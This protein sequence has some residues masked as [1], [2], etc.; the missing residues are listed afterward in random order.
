M[1]RG[2]S[3]L[4]RLIASTCPGTVDSRVQVGDLVAVANPN[5]PWSAG[6]DQP[7]GEGAEVHSVPLGTRLAAIGSLPLRPL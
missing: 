4:M 5:T 3:L 1:L 7:F 6:N 2:S